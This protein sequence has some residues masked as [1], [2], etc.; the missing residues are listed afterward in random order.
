MADHQ[1]PL[2]RASTRKGSPGRGA[3]CGAHCDLRSLHARYGAIEQRALHRPPGLEPAALCKGPGYR[4]PCLS[5]E[6]AGSA[7]HQRGPRTQ[8][9]RR[10][11]LGA[12]EGAA[13]RDRSGPA[14]HGDQGHTLLGEEAPDPPVDRPSALRN[15]RWRVCG[16]RPGLSGLLCRPQA[17]HLHAKDVHPPCRAGG[18]GVAA[19][20]R[21]ADAAGGGGAVHQGCRQRDECAQ[22]HGVCHGRATAVGTGHC[23]PQARGAL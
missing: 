1:K 10:G 3:S 17:R 16:R 11:A 9:H 5:T 7:D 21:P 22:R 2:H 4:P 23:H 18:S 6:P 14:C 20:E 13:G 8:D 12:G 15:L 19:V